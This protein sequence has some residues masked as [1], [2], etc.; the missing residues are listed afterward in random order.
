MSDKVMEAFYHLH[1]H[2][3]VSNHEVE[4][5][6]YVYKLMT[7]SGFD[8][9]RFNNINGLYCDIGN[10]Q[11]AKV[12]IG[13]RADI[14][15]LH[16]EV[17]G[18]LTANHSCGHDAHMA[19]VFGAMLKLKSMDLGNACVRFIFQPAEELGVGAIGVCNEGIIEGLDYLYGIHLR[20]IE[21]LRH[22]YVASDIQHGAV[23]DITFKIVGDD[24]HGA[25]PHL[26]HNAIE[27]ASEMITHISNIHINP[28][29]PAS[30]KVTQI[31]TMGNSI[32]IIPG[33]IMLGIDL[34]AQTN[35]AMTSLV[36]Q[37][38]RIIETVAELNDVKIKDFHTHG[39]VAAVKHPD[40][41]ANIK[42]AII[43]TLGE[44]YYHPPIIT[45]GGD[46]FNFY[47][48]KYP[49]LKSGMIGLGCDLTPGLH[50]PNMRFNHDAI[51]T[52]VDVIAE[53]VRIT[54]K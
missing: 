37:V 40:A 14:D 5:T 42:Q 38:T 2:P 15:A 32:N 8:P 41:V 54:S 23:S 17:D 24:A 36:E 50:H 1:E 53:T 35:E 45:S 13:V 22:G 51:H 3:E 44:A 18:E 33:S 9:H 11:K 25:R 47:N 31:N 4:T 30:A 6:A 19:M 43:N 52:G 20:P 10:F 26:N 49:H 48:Q 12:K 21:E 7:E 39:G 46:D 29:I 16:Q 28:Q 34:R 27:V